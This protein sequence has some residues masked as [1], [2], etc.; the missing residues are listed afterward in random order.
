MKLGKVLV[1]SH[2]QLVPLKGLDII[3]TIIESNWPEHENHQYHERR[4]KLIRCVYL[5]VRDI[6]KLLKQQDFRDGFIT[7]IKLYFILW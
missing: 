7:I 4:L 6:Y 5:K 2:C 1:S 3:Q